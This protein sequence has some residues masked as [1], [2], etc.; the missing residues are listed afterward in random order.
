VEAAARS[1]RPSLA[2]PALERLLLISKASGTDWAVGMELRARALLGADTDCEELYRE[3]IVRLARTRVA[4][5][6]GRTHLVYGEWLRRQGRRAEAREQLRVAHKSLSDMGVNAFARRAEHELAATGEHVRRRT[7]GLLDTLTMQ[8]L[9]IARRAA[10]GA[11]SKEIAAV[12]FLS[13]RTIDAHLR[14]IF[15]KTGVTSRRQ[16]R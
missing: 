6:L 12:L 10:G 7:P 5:Y 8:E 16:L 11:T 13:P 4:V 3:A 1:G 14:S 15:R 9:N 2:S